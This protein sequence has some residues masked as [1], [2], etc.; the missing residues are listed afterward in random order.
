MHNLKL[1]HVNLSEENIWYSTNL[2]RPVLSGF[3]ISRSI[4]EEQMEMTKMTEYP[5]RGKY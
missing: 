5:G 1:V 2:H 3:E 4:M